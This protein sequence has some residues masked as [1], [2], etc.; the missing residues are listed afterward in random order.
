MEKIQQNR[1]SEAAGQQ[2]DS[3][4]TGQQPGRQSPAGT[5]QETG[6]PQKSADKTEQHS[7]SGF[8][9]QEGETLGTP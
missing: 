9:Q 6:N 1:S 8:P 2:N 5:E 3:K 7:E 4:I